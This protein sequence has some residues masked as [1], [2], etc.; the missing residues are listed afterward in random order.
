MRR[1][2]QAL[3]EMQR[4]LKPGGHILLLEHGRSRT[5]QIASRYLDA[6]LPDHLKKYGWYG[7][8]LCMLFCVALAHMPEYC[9]SV[10]MRSYW[11][12][13]IMRLIDESGLA[14]DELDE[15]H[16]GTGYFVVARKK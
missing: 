7:C 15:F 9:V 2:K 14:V 13:D 10:P 3:S 5:W 1:A 12:R 16:L 11:N 8:G 4:V 6:S